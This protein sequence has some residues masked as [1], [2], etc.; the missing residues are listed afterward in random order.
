MD[1]LHERLYIMLASA[2][3]CKVFPQNAKDSSGSFSEAEVRRFSV[4]EVFLIISQI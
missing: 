2:T 1:T 4:K 3:F